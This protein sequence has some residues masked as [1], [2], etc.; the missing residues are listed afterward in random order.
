M[1]WT[2]V[3]NFL[4]CFLCFLVALCAWVPAGPGKRGHLPS[5]GNVQARLAS[6]TTFLF[7]Q[8]EPNS[9]SPNTIHRLKLRLWLGLRPVSH[10]GAY[11]ILISDRPSSCIEMGRFV[12]QRRKQGREGRRE[13]REKKGMGG[14]K[15]VRTEDGQERKGLDIA[16]PCKNS[17]GCWWLCV[18]FHN[19]WRNYLVGDWAQGQGT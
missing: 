5:S 12:A 10:R 2:L 6:I 11:S 17:Y 4:F 1:Q 3:K 18:Q 7:A 19:K 13:W 15:R 9:L 14:K 8:K 16:H